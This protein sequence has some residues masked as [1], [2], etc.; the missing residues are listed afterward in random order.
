M[1][2]LINGVRVMDETVSIIIPIYKVEQYIIDT[3]KSVIN[4][5]Y[6]NIQLIL[7]DDCGGDQS[8]NIAEK[9]LEDVG[10]PYQL[11]RHKKNMGQAAARNTGTQNATGKWIFYLDSDDLIASETVEVLVNQ[12]VKYDSKVVFSNFRYIEN[13]LEINKNIYEDEFAVLNQREVLSK[14]LKREIK[15]LA[16]GTLYERMLLLN[17][18]LAFEQIP[19]SED[20]HFLWRLLSYIDKVVYVNAP[21]YQY[22]LHE[23]SIMSSTEV[24][25]MLVG[26]NAIATLKKYYNKNEDIG[27]YIE[28]RWVLG[29]LNSASKIVGFK[30]WK[31]L[32]DEMNGRNNF[33]ILLTFPEKRVRLL[34]ILGMV[35]PKCYYE[36]VKRRKL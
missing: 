4:Q 19:W 1:N 33:N 8:C 21:L 6:S 26:Y 35:F 24:E 14:F 23:N 11:V 29:T 7:V 17:N 9:Y 18:S 27:K 12:A 10:Y 13:V 25:K 15:L 5:T 3:L 16:P 34:S 31:Q 2:S 36:L 32:R 28:P 22:L 30:K 20:Q